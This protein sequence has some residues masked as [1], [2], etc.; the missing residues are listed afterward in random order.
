MG[1]LRNAFGKVSLAALLCSKLAKKKKY[2]KNKKETLAHTKETGA[3]K[4]LRVQTQDRARVALL[5]AAGAAARI[6]SI[7]QVTRSANSEG[8]EVTIFPLSRGPLLIFWCIFLK[9]FFLG[10]HGLWA[11]GAGG[12]VLLIKLWPYHNCTIAHPAFSYT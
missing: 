6:S 10:M 3:F 7:P 2:P 11:T 8:K 4:R 1:T 9:S 12:L 5:S